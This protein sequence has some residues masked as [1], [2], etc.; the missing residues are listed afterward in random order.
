MLTRSV[1]YSFRLFIILSSLY[2]M[3]KS[4]AI[5]NAIEAAFKDAAS[6][7]FNACETITSP[8]IPVSLHSLVFLSVSTVIELRKHKMHFLTFRV[9][10]LLL[11]NAVLFA[12]FKLIRFKEV[13]IKFCYFGKNLNA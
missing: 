4:S 8:T 9:L 12:T 6:A 13:E 2:A 11:F 7:V 10:F 5:K 3:D 1:S